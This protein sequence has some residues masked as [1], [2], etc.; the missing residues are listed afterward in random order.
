LLELLGGD[1]PSGRYRAS[2]LG[3]EA[4]DDPGGVRELRVALT[5]DDKR[6]ARES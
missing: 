3:P 4:H 1:L 5:V 2:D 6:G